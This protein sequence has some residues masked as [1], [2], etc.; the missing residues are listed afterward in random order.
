MDSRHPHQI[1]V[2]SQYDI[3]IILR[4]FNLLKLGEPK[5]KVNRLH[6]MS[7]NF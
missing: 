7:I 6:I 3:Y 2:D 5:N 4:K 1:N